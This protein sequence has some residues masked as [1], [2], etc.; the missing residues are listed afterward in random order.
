MTYLA[1][2]SQKEHPS[3]HLYRFVVAIDWNRCP[4]FQ[5]EVAELTMD[6]WD[7]SKPMMTLGLAAVD[8]WKAEV[9]YGLA[10]VLVTEVVVD[11]TKKDCAIVVEAVR[12]ATILD[13]AIDHHQYHPEDS[14]PA[15][16]MYVL[17]VVAVLSFD[18]SLVDLL[19]AAVA[20]LA[21]NT[22][23]IKVR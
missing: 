2:A 23:A 20:V 1:H 12:G 13:T 7:Q 21:V 8:E 19:E 5:T 11:H 9:H 17:C 10:R 15:A 14:D 18:N 4:N 22:S 16:A 3:V 6:A